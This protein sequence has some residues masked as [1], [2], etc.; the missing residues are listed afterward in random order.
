MKKLFFSAFKSFFTVFIFISF[1]TAAFSQSCALPAGCTK[2]VDRTIEIIVPN[3]SN[4]FC[5][6]YVTY[7]EVVCGGDYNIYNFTYMSLG[8]SCSDFATRITNDPQFVRDLDVIAGRQV[9]DFIAGKVIYGQGANPNNYNCNGTSSKV[10]SVIYFRASCIAIWEGVTK[11]E[12][13]IPGSLTI[14]SEIQNGVFTFILAPLTIPIN[15]SVF[16]TVACG[17]GC[18]KLRRTYC[19]KN[20]KLSPTETTTAT[21]PAGVICSFS[22]PPPPADPK[23]TWER[24]SPCFTICDN[25]PMENKV[26]KNTIQSTETTMFFR[27]PVNGNLILNF[28]QEI[29]GTVEIQDIDGKVQRQ[30]LVNQDKSISIDMY[31][32]PVGVYFVVLKHSDGRVETKKLVNQ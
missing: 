12:V 9:A 11:I 20:G 15:Q 4:D 27:N 30:V 23:V 32:I 10:V 8:P 16:A 29:N 3:Y 14:V 25:I 18:C 26:V 13:V 21:N 2:P 17:D 24:S 5:K 31:S 6:I 28:L 1:S 22:V 7:T 19:N